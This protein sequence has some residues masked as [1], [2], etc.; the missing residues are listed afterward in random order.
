MRCSPVRRVNG[1]DRFGDRVSDCEKPVLRTGC[2]PNH[3]SFTDC[4]WMLYGHR[5]WILPVH[6]LGVIADY[7]NR[8][9]E[10][11]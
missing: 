1:K 11:A 8:A 6:L 10:V 5:S 4:L 2:P 3:L 9:N 7:V